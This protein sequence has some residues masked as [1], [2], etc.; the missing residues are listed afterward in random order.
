MTRRAMVHPHLARDIASHVIEKVWADDTN[1]Y[2]QAQP[3]V[4]IGPDGEA[5][6]VIAAA[7]MS[8]AGENALRI[9]GRLWELV[10]LQRP[11]DPPLVYGPRHLFPSEEWDRILSKCVALT[12]DVRCVLSI[13]EVVPITDEQGRADVGATSAIVGAVLPSAL[14]PNPDLLDELLTQVDIITKEA[15]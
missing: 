9:H 4:F 8:E 13:F 14:E 12:S 5:V 6:V 10:A 3:G 1:D 11:Y 7:Q 2:E 15:A